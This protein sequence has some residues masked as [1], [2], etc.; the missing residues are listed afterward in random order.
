MISWRRCRRPIAAWQVWK[1]LVAPWHPA[2]AGPVNTWPARSMVW[3]DSIQAPGLLADAST[4]V[5]LLL[6]II[7]PS[8]LAGLSAEVARSGVIRCGRIQLGMAIW[9][10]AKAA[11][12]MAMAGMVRRITIPTVTPRV[13]ANAA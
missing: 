4:V 6:P 3:L 11:S 10:K 13:K 5:E 9:T 8:M 12:V 1:E 7:K 2:G